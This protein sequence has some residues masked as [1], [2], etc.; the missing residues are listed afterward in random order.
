MNS[1]RPTL[2]PPEALIRSYATAGAYTDCYVMEV[3]RAVA[4]VDYVEAFYTSRVFKLERAVLRLVAFKP[5]TDAGARQLALGTARS[6]AAWSVEERTASQLLLRDFLGRTRSWLMVEPMS[7]CP[8]RT[9]LY[10][11]T[12]V[13]PQKSGRDG[14]QDIGAVF[15]AL[16]G[17]HRAYTLTLMRSAR[18]R[19]LA[20]AP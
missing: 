5:S 9:R 2:T 11:G 14:G 7:G 15:R 3:A 20:A 12:A 19:L 10:F 6:F 13:T 18:H 17:F 1:I 8:A 16:T 4:L